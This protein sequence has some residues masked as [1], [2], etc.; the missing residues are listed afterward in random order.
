MQAVAELLVNVEFAHSTF[1][2][3]VT[4]VVVEMPAPT[5]LRV[6]SRTWLEP[7]SGSKLFAR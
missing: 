7:N 5:R 6:T 3:S 2:P 4:D 1:C